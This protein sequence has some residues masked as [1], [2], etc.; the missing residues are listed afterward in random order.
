M[1]ANAVPLPIVSDVMVARV[2]GAIAHDTV[3]R[4]GLSLTPEARAVLA[5]ADPES[6][7]IARKAGEAVV[8]QVV[9]RL[10]PLSV[11]ATV[12]RGVEAFALGLLLERYLERVRASGSVRI[13]IDEARRVRDAIDR[14]VLRVISPAIRPA[15][16][17]MSHG[18]EDLRSETTRFL[19]TLLLTGASLPS[20]FERRLEAAFDDVAAETPGL[21]DG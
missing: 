21:R 4:R 2:R 6:R 11:V 15:L 3:A 12:S 5:S 8:R 7:A 20:Y 19:D 17:T 13:D 9:K 16:T 10:G 1:A 14:A 18:S